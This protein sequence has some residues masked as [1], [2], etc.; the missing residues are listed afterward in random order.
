MKRRAVLK[1]RATAPLCPPVHPR[2]SACGFWSSRTRRRSRV[3]W[4]EA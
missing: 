1:G 2:G 4:N 3:C